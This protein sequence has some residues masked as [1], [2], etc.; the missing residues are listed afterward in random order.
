MTVQEAGTRPLKV[1]PVARPR[2]GRTRRG[3]S[4]ALLKAG[5]YAALTVAA[6]IAIMPFVWAFLTSV[7]RPVD[8]F[9][10][11]PTW[12]FSPTLEAYRILWYEHDFAAFLGNTLL[13]AALTVVISL[14]TAAPAAYALARYTSVGG[15]TLLIVALAFRALPR[16]AVVLPFYYISRELGLYD[17]RTALVIAL[18][19][20]NQPFA[21]WL[22][23]NFFASIPE[24]LDEAAMVDGCSRLRGFRLIILPL[25]KPGLITTAIFTFMLA[26][27]D[28]LIPVIITQSNAVTLPVFIAQFSTENVQDW[29]VISAASISLALPIIALV[30]LAQKYL[31]AG[32]TAGSVKG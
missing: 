25:V 24:A 13:V 16:M 8:A 11:P 28:Y 20:V 30:M 32:L 5:A 31:V 17:T 23:R 27:Q 2:P 3:T 29:P 26:Y 21:I 12:S 1:A 18:V 14:L 7:K 15:L 22:L 4:P 6:L 19:A 9:S 10:L